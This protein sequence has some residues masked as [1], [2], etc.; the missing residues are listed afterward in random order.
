M[1][2]GGKMKF[3]RKCGC[4]NGQAGWTKSDIWMAILS[5]VVALGC[6]FGSLCRSALA[7]SAPP[8]LFIEVRQAQITITPRTSD[9]SF[10]LETSIRSS[11]GT[12]MRDLFEARAVSPD[13]Y[14]FRNRYWK[15]TFWKVD[16]AKHRV[17]KVSGGSFGVQGGKEVGL[18]GISVVVVKLPVHGPQDAPTEELQLRIARSILTYTASTNSLRLTL[19]GDEILGPAEWEIQEA[20]PGIFHLRLKRLAWLKTLFWKIDA[21]ALKVSCETEGRYAGPGEE[22]LWEVRTSNF[23]SIKDEKRIAEDIDMKTAPGEKHKSEWYESEKAAYRGILQRGTYDV[24]V[25]PFQ[26]QNHATDRID[27]LL[28]TRYLVWKIESSTKQKVPDPTL[29]AKALGELQRR[30]DDK[31]V[32]ELAHSLKVKTL[33]RG[34]VGHDL[35]NKAKISIVVQTVDRDG[36][37]ALSPEMILDFDDIA[38]SDERLPSDVFVSMLDS[39]I[40]K[41]PFKGGKSSPARL[42]EKVKRLPVPDSLAAVTDKA[43]DSPVINTYYLQWLGILYPEPS[44]AREYLFERSLVS[45]LDVDPKSP[46]YALLKARAYFYLH[47]RPAAVAVMKAPKTSE[48]RAFRAI[49]DGNLLDARKYTERIASPLDKIIAEI[50]LIDLRWQYDDKPTSKEVTDLADKYPQWKDLVLR[51]IESND[52]WQVQSNKVVKS[53]LDDLLPVPG[54]SLKDILKKKVLLSEFDDDDGDID[55]SVYRHRMRLIEKQPGLFINARWWQTTKRDALDLLYAV[56]EANILNKLRLPI[57]VQALPERALALVDR[58]EPI[59]R[60]NP[61]FVFLKARALW[62]VSYTKQGKEKMDFAD[63]ARVAQDDASYWSQGQLSN[64]RGRQTRPQWYE[65]GKDIPRRWYWDVISPICEATNKYIPAEALRDLGKKYPLCLPR[66]LNDLDNAVQYTNAEFST[67]QQYSD[68]LLRYGWTESAN[69]LLRDYADRFVGSPSKQLYLAKIMEDSGDH[70][71]AAKLYRAMIA[72]TPNVWTPYEKVGR[73]L[74]SR[75]MLRAAFEL[76]SG[77]PPFVES[78][79]AGSD[80]DL[81]TVMLSKYAYRAAEDLFS[82]GS[83]E[84]ATPLYQLSAGYETGSASGMI[85]QIMLERLAGNFVTAAQESL[86]LAKRYTRTTYYAAYAEMLHLL[87]YH[88]EAWTIFETFSMSDKL[89]DH[90]RPVLVGFR[91][92]GKSPAE[93]VKW[94]L[95]HEL[96]KISISDA[97]HF[98]LDAY[99]IDRAPDKRVLDALVDVEKK[100]SFVQNGNGSSAAGISTR[101]GVPIE[102][103]AGWAVWFADGYNK[104]RAGRYKE[105]YA[106]FSG[107]HEAG[108]A[109]SYRMFS[110][111]LPYGAWSA[112]KSG[113]LT[114]IES[115]VSQYEKK[116]GETFDFHL[117]RA[118][119]EGGKKNHAVALNNLEAARFKLDS[120]SDRPFYAWYQLVE[121]CELLFGETAYPGYRDLALKFAK[122]CQPLRPGYAWS[123]AVEAR[124][125]TSE[126]DRIRALG[127][128]LYLDK[129]SVRISGFSKAERDRALSWLKDNNPFLKQSNRETNL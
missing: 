98:L 125:T 61:D 14:H 62:M 107:G 92:Q 29:V 90:I 129:D 80:E 76:Y 88:E 36:Q 106:M 119:I 72:E 55:L 60:G 20:M 122:M 97:Q 69:K 10:A 12:S 44:V 1:L 128:A 43:S 15:E 74:I 19:E 34:Y 118:F 89:Y 77:Y 41:L 110:W 39:V 86:E 26:V 65:Y 25:V 95:Q 57:L 84:Y 83:V 126:Q 35:N 103:G 33:V 21:M 38:F 120:S 53:L 127:I 18:Q 71:G 111:A 64:P 100:M 46:D 81:D 75:G 52:V 40:S 104:I 37:A 101:S 85:S 13:I 31:E 47:R 94:L 16:I 59:Y 3:Y 91:M 66:E 2:D 5:L 99:L 114:E 102:K 48:E 70:D 7:V 68:K 24:L 109:N 50:E 116:M 115:Y 112:L 108:Q 8:Q 73:S 121:A 22:L 79:K 117:A 58:Y 124:Y 67:L 87:G 32:V 63:R 51:R 78:Q 45:L 123:Y 113:H 30:F 105:A 4:L 17:Y 23:E 82:R 56:S 49:L 11:T 6:L 96:K 27:R 93:Q 54:F 42:Y 9:V 28:M